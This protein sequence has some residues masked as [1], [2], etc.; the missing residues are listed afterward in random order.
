MFMRTCW[1]LDH[2]AHVRLLAPYLRCS[3]N[4]DVIIATRR[5]E[6]KALIDGGDGCIPRRQIHWVDRPVGDGKRKKAL[7]RWSSSHKFLAECCKLGQPI[8][9]I[10]AVGASIELMAWKSPF[11]RKRLNSISHRYYITDTEVNHIAHN[12]ALK[13]ATH[14]IVP[15]HW[16][17]SIDGGFISQAEKAEIKVLRLDGLHGH[18]HLRPGIHPSSVSD[19][20]RVIVRMLKGGGIHD[21]EEIITIPE[22]TFDGL[23]VTCADEDEYAGDPWMLDREVAKHD[24]VITQSVTLASEAALLGTPTLLVSKAERGF[25]NR[26][27]SD[28]YPIF[29]WNKECEG[30]SWKNI[31]AQFLA[32]IHLTDAIEVESWPNARGQLAEYLAMKLID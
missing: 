5:K 17:E 13:S 4:N 21:E 11:L 6:V 2:P 10:V 16:N 31:L 23:E 1:V 28:G 29:R 8:S 22:S 12:L 14:I 3:N 20:P 27:E 24:G 18:V 25:L 7:K 32:G 26:L 30:D 9:R 15:N 19:P